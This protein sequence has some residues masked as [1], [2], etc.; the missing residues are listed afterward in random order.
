MG[1]I[2]DFYYSHSGWLAIGPPGFEPG[3]AS[4]LGPCSCK[5]WDCPLLARGRLEASSLVASCWSSPSWS[6]R[7]GTAKTVNC[8]YRH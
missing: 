7:C 8:A 3:T 2:V 6:E 5:A 4:V 1:E